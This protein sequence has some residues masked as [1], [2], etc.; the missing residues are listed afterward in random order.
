MRELEAHFAVP[1]NEGKLGNFANSVVNKIKQKF[2]Q[3]AA[4][5]PKQQFNQAAQKLAQAGGKLSLQ[6]IHDKFGKTLAALGIIIALTS[7]IGQGLSTSQADMLTDQIAEISMSVDDLDHH[8]GDQ[9]LKTSSDGTDSF[10]SSSSS[11]SSTSGN[12]TNLSDISQTGDDGEYSSTA[13]SV[14]DAGNDRGYVQVDGD[15]N[16]NVYVGDKDSTDMAYQQ[17]K[18]IQDL[19]HDS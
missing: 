18:D 5:A 2:D 14:T 3:P 4:E 15:D 11:T 13:L 8:S 7:A 16:T 19:R 12:S 6:K 9:S 10:R 17:E 1:L